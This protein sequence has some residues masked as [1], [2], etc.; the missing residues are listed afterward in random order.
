MFLLVFTRSGQF[1]EM[2][3][4]VIFRT[5]HIPESFGEPSLKI[6]RRLLVARTKTVKFAGANTYIINVAH[7]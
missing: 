4:V 2:Q 6:P 5:K 1:F 7:F 3:I